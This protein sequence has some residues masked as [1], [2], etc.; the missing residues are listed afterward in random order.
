MIALDVQQVSLKLFFSPVGWDT[1]CKSATMYLSYLAIGVFGVASGLASSLPEELQC[2][3]HTVDQSTSLQYVDILVPL[4][5]GIDIEDATIE[6]LQQYM[7]A[8]N[9]TS[10]DL[11]NCYIARIEQTNK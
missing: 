8:G 11:V 7:V 5:N 10:V 6:T 9:L 4:C 2:K 3:F 1:V